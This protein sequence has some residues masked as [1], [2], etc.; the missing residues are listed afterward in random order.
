MNKIGLIAGGGEYPVVFAREAAAKG[1]AVHT[2]ALEGA[3]DSRL[4]A[5]SASIKYFKLGQ[6][7]APIKALRDA[8]VE[9]A[10]MTGL[11]R[12]GSIFSV[13]SA[14]LRAAA[15]LA[16]L[17]DFRAESILGAIVKEF[18]KDGIEIISSATFLE[19]LLPKPG[20]L[21][22]VRPG[23]LQEKSIE[24]GQRIARQLAAAD[25]GLTAVV[26]DRMIVA[27]EAL[28]GTDQCILRSGELYRA[29]V[30]GQKVDQS[31]TSGLVVVK[32]ARPRQDFRFDLPVIGVRT[33]ES[34]ARAGAKTLAIEAGS[35][36]MLSRQELLS[37]ADSEGISVTAFTA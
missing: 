34:M 5:L 1:C 14:D 36:L 20:L 11:V 4:E 31:K 17:P 6:L 19:H 24:F 29:A 18:A 12:H 16:R 13:L 30:A 3:A 37:K 15:F 7:S 26:C 10:V 22:R 35:T 32:A 8:G 25:V 28:E 9:K 27:L 2:V 21:G 23:K 33:I